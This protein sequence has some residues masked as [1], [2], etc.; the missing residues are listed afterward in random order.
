LGG[1]SIF[2][3]RKEDCWLVKG[4]RPTPY[5]VKAGPGG[6]FLIKISW[7]RQKNTPQKIAL[8]QISHF[9]PS[10]SHQYL[11]FIKNKREKLAQKHKKALDSYVSLRKATVSTIN[12]ILWC[13]KSRPGLSFLSFAG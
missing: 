10:P 9:F 8:G 2:L 1:G 4:C 6:N 13:K 3:A 12:I 11:A 5:L 7:V